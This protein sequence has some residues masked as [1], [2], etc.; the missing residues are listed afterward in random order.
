MNEKD[1]QNIFVSQVL[2]ASSITPAELSELIN[3][4][5]SIDVSKV[6][7]VYADDYKFRMLEAMGSNFKSL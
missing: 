6:L 7:L 1:Y 3:L 4:I 2:N 5:G